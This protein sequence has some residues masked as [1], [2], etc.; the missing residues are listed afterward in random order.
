MN[1]AIDALPFE[2]HKPGYRFCGPGT[3]LQSRLARGDQGINASDAACREHDIAYHDH[4]GTAERLQADRQLA[5]RAFSRLRSRDASL[6]ERA[7]ALGVGTVMSLKSKI[8]GELVC[9]KLLRDTIHTQEGIRKKVRNA[10]RSRRRRRVPTTTPTTLPPSRV[11][12]LKSRLRV[13]PF[14]RK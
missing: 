11:A 1:R 9:P 13:V 6:G 2:P 8:G 3:R 14:A 7:A 10:Y 5:D 4:K 12:P